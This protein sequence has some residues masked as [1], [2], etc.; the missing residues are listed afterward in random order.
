MTLD[1]GTA[2]IVLAKRVKRSYSEPPKVSDSGWIIFLPGMSTFSVDQN[3]GAVKPCLHTS[4]A[5]IIQRTE[6][7]KAKISILHA[8]LQEMLEAV[9]KGLRFRIFTE[10]I[11]PLSLN[12]NVDH[13]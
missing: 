2:R 8:G 11:E 10:E 3:G 1:L 12:A 6:E 5:K 4:M 9:K 7:E 13:E